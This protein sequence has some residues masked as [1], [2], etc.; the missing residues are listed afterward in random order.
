[1][2]VVDAVVIAWV[3]V[4]ALLG[5]ARGMTEQV[6]SL[7]GL[8][9]G[10]VA[11]SRLAPHLLPGGQESVWLPLVA[12]AGAVIGAALVQAIL[13]RLS[14]PL[15]RRMLRDPLRAVDQGGGLVVGAALGIAL[16]WM[17]AAVALYQPGDRVAGL[18]DQV[19]R[20]A[21]LSSALDAVPPDA[22]LGALARI[23]PFP[24]IPLPAAALPPPDPSV[25]E[26]PGARL[27]ADSVVQLRGRACGL[28]KQ[29]SGWVVAD[30]L[31]ATN[32]HVIAG[33]RDTT[34]TGPDGAALPAEPV[35]VDAR[36]DVALLRADGLDLDPLELGDAPGAAEPVVLLGY[37]SGGPL[38]A[39]AATASAPRTVLVPD[40]YGRL[41]GPRVVV[42]T[43]GTLGPGS[44]GGP[45]IDRRG[46]VVA[47]IFGGDADG[48]SGAAV[49][50]GPIRE[51]L[52]S[53]LRPVPAGPCA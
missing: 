23:D 13:L 14:A 15:R 35:H 45:V 47:M 28:V 43:R 37:P 32:A 38:V 40:A 12:L 1:V 2:T 48:E 17:A 33:Q 7:F 4:W 30:D 10:A 3:G 6:L 21:I 5:A 34:L 36:N 49:P 22:V 25:L 18:R 19:Q 11:G 20:S 9:V 53:A 16:A 42:V 26:A 24:V 39:E 52:G 27:A 29:G 44:S 31:V 46:R 41:S 51:G 8:A 50:P